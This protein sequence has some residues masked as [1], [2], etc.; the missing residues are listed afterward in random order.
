MQKNTSILKIM[1]LKTEK[2]IVML[3]IVYLSFK[4]VAKVDL[5]FF[6]SGQIHIPQEESSLQHLRF[7]CYLKYRKCCIFYFVIQLLSEPDKHGWLVQKSISLIQDTK[8]I[9]CTI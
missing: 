2:K 9:V 7:T 8:L 6:L 3:L 1:V 5:C 4:L